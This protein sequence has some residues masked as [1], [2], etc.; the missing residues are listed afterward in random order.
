MHASARSLL[1][2]PAKAAMTALVVLLAAGTAALAE[3][4]A[5]SSG[6]AGPPPR[7]GNVYDHKD[8]Q[9]TAADVSARETAAGFTA[10]GPD[11]GQ[12]E[13]EVKQLLD[14]TDALDKQSERNGRGDRAGSSTQA[15]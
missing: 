1:R 12:V 11:K 5:I 8:H 3:G 6:A 10:R 14:Q 13:E 15:R 9:P 7:E 2:P 4:D